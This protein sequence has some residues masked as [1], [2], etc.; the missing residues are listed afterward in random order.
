MPKEFGFAV[1]HIFFTAFDIQ[2]SVRSSLCFAPG[3]FA[4]QNSPAN[5]K[6]EG[7]VQAQMRNVTYHFSDAVAVNIKSLNGELVPVGKMNSPSS[8]TEPR[9]TFAYAQRRSP[10]IR[11]AWQTFSIPTLS[12]VRLSL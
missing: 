1:P 11:R 4:G 2:V 6:E 5:D 7:M 8:T 12:R 10:S 9:L 3:I